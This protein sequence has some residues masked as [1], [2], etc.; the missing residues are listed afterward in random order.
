M[1]PSDSASLSTEP[2]VPTN[3]VKTVKR[4][5]KSKR[6]A[7]S[8]APERVPAVVAQNPGMAE[9]WVKF[10]TAFSNQL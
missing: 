4:R 6:N 10:Y 8:Q 7:S 2:A 9:G 3:E 1:K 5:R